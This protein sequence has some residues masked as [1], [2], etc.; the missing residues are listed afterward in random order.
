MKLSS[1]TLAL[2]ALGLILCAG[3]PVL[4]Q[5]SPVEGELDTTATVQKILETDISKI[6]IFKDGQLVRKIPG[7]EFQRAEKFQGVEALGFCCQEVSASPPTP[8]C[9]NGGKE[10]LGIGDVCKFKKKLNGWMI[11]CSK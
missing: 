2:S 10:Q 1:L 7:C 11:Y 4:G 3:S 6:L 9:D 5:A 8:D